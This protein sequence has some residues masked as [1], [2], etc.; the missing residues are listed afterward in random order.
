MEAAVR[1]L[2][3]PHAYSR[4]RR[5]GASEPDARC[6]GPGT[7]TMDLFLIRIP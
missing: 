4:E 2:S 1:F 3:P 5:A 6:Q 7:K